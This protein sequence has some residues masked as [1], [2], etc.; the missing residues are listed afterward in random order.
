MTHMT[1]I[2][3]EFNVISE[4]MVRSAQT[5]HLSCLKI[6]IISKKTESSF[7]LNFVT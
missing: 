7:D 3:A 1:H 4:P 5:V 2:S 6:S